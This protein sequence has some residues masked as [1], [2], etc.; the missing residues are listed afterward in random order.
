MNTESLVSASAST[1]EVSD[2]AK[3]IS[4]P[5]LKALLNVETID[6]V[7]NPTATLDKKTGLMVNKLF[8]STPHGTLK[9]QASIDFK[10]PMRFM[11]NG[12][13]ATGCIVNVTE[14]IVAVI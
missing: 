3:F 9:I 4:I 2:K 5:E 1:S 12:D 6:I 7:R 11:Y 13:I 8:G 10:K 14:N